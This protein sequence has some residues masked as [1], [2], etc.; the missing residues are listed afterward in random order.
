MPVYINPLLYQSQDIAVSDWITLLT[1]CLAPLIAH[2]LI[3]AP[4][5]TYLSLSRPAWHE[6]ICHYN[7]TSILWRYGIIADRRIRARN[8][9]RFDLAATN[10]LFWTDRGWDGSEVMIQY[11]RSQCVQLPDGSRVALLSR[12]A[13]KT[14][15]ITVQGV[16]AII[17]LL[18]SQ[19]DPSAPS[20]TILMA[21]D[22]IFF[23]MALFGLLRLCSCIWLT[24]EFSF[25]SMEDVLMSS[26]QPLGCN[27]T[28]FELLAA[29][30]IMEEPQ[31]FLSPTF[32]GSRVFRLLYTSIIFGLFALAL[33]F[34]IPRSGNAFYTT[35]TLVV[36]I[37]YLM[38][39]GMTAIMTA[40]YIGYKGA[41]STVLPCISSAWYKFYT[42]VV[43]G[44][45]IS[46]IVVACIETR[47]TPC[48][49]FT[50]GPGIQADLLAC[51]RGSFD[52]IEHRQVTD[53]P[54][55]GTVDVGFQ[56]FNN[57]SYVMA[58]YEDKQ[59]NAFN[60]TRMCF[61]NKFGI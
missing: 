57:A 60:V 9:D 10:A 2:V 40:W 15:I 28:S 24:D 48:G 26:A 18:G 29:N 36:I 37:F 31:R 19:V 34:A 13:I 5:P 30:P 42:G 14:L 58:H 56:H 25:A 27:T 39:I 49:K 52:K 20:F 21:V 38:V 11:S 55:N 8:W 54:Y 61:S 41:T 7:P 33:V 12:D 44:F 17:L 4:S 45:G 1:L 23:P 59:Q 3:G 50:S 16:Q 47:K 53:G 22:I 35:T 46:V 6:R 51:L 43:I 32:W